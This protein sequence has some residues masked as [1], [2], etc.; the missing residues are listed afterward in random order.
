MNRTIVIHLEGKMESA[1][2]RMIDRPF[3]FSCFLIK[4]RLDWLDIIAALVDVP[5]L[6]FGSTDIGAQSYSIWGASKPYFCF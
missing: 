3:K 6:N 2:G 5:V 4:G 1:F